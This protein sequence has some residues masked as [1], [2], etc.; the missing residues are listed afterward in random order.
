MRL[1][2]DRQL[3]HLDLF[4]GIG[5]FALAAQRAGFRTVGF[6]EVEPYSCSV[7]A[8]RFPSVPNLGDV[9]KLNSFAGVGP[10]TVI[11]GGFPCQ[12][13]SCAGKQR[14]KDDVRHLWPAMLDVIKIIRPAWVIGENVPGL[15]H[16]GGLDLVCDDL[17]NNGYEAQ[18]F[19]IPA[20]AVGLRQRRDRVWIVAANSDSNGNG[21]QRCIDEPEANDFAWSQV[22]FERLVSLSLQRGVPSRRSGGISDGIPNRAHRAK[23]LGNAV[24]PQIPEKLFNFIAQVETQKLTAIGV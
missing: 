16:L 23:G 11:T 15:E 4:S 2:N 10:V 22:E 18:P 9:R 7:L 21:L 20:C 24:V 12:P 5:G 17:E 13:F 3:T 14:G 6:S 1:S 19:V 8:E